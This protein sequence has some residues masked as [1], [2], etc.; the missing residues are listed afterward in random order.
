MCLQTPKTPTLQYIN[1]LQEC[2]DECV[3]SNCFQS[4]CV[5]AVTKSDVFLPANLV[6][7][8]SCGAKALHA[9]IVDKACV[10]E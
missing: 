1:G 6:C 2:T 10:P 9:V 3:I 5:C 7:G 4:S 8:Y